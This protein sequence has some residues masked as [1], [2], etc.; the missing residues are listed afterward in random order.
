MSRWVSVG[1]LFIVALLTFVFV[2]DAAP[3]TRPPRTKASDKTAPAARGAR[4]D[5]DGFSAAKNNV[6]L[7][8]DHDANIK[9][10]QEKKLEIL[11]ER[12]NVMEEANKYGK[13]SQ[14]Q[15][16]QATLDALRFELEL[17]DRPHVRIG[18]L[19]Q[20]LTILQRFET[21]AEEAFTRARTDPN[22]VVGAH[23]R[24]THARITRLNS[25]ISLEKE[26]IAQEAAGGKKEKE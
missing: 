8:K 2:V 15:M 16:D 14:N 20:M 7:G 13:A 19:E 4:G 22:A 18:I 6:V 1:G 21:D 17:Q 26:K 3:P 24:Y 11:H 9:A 12:Q 25:Q 23:G 10:L 5:S